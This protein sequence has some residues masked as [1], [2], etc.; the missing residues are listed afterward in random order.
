MKN[1]TIVGAGL[2]GSLLSIYLAKRGHNVSVYE[3]RPDMRLANIS[4]GR[5]INLALSDRGWRGLERAGLA[6]EI[7]KIIIPMPGRMMHATNGTLTFQPYGK[8]G[9]AIN[10]ISRG[11]LN[12]TLMNA[13]EQYPNVSYHFN[14]RAVDCDLN[15]TTMTFENSE[16]NVKSVVQSDVIFAADGA[17]SVIRDKMQKTDR[18]NYSQEY[19]EHGYKEL[20][21]PP[22]SNGEF[23]IEKNA[24]HI[25]ARKS[26]MM[27]ALPNTDATYTCTLFLPF[28][29]TADTPGFDQLNTKEDVM[30]FFN[31]Y[32]PDAVPLMPTLLEDFFANPTSSLATVRTYPWVRGNVALIGDAAHAICP[33]FGQGMICSFE[34]CVVLDE[35]VERHGDNWQAALDEYQI[36]RKP[37]GD[38]IAQLALDNFIEMRDKVADPKFLLRKKIEAAMHERFP[39]HYK[40]LYTMVVFSPDIPYA[41]AYRRGKENDVLLEKILGLPNI[42]TTWN[43][44]DGMN[45]IGEMLRTH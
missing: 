3:R 31:T 25:W 12:K 7:E 34:D 35:C 14:Q 22:G 42:E 6:S 1:I 27:I 37:N 19:L 43:T 4:A 40:P 18:F 13:A 8:N 10:S 21:I 41:E 9:Q 20:V 39:N 24:L 11:L 28:I 17:F 45:T 44:D 16:T 29:S 23:M 33:F 26:F 5:S 30:N 15:T 2:A 38:A 36:L 32:F